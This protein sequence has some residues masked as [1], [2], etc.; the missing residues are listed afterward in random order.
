MHK[1]GGV[2]MIKF[3]Y[4]KSEDAERFYEILNNIDSTYFYATI[5][6]S[7]EIEREWILK[8]RQVKRLL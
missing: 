4:P 6:D 3:R 8:I 7:V 1:A 5:P 2:N